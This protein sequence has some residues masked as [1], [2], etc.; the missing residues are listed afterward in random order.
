MITRK[1]LYKLY[2]W[3]RDKSFPLKKAPT[4]THYSNKDIYIC[5]LK[6]VRKNTNIKKNLMS[7]EIYKERMRTTMLS[8]NGLCSS[9]FKP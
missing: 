1:N 5:G 2:D 8:C 7:E 9:S 3:A 4:S 6:F